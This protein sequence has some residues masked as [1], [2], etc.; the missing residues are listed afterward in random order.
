MTKSFDS[1]IPGIE[2]REAGWMRIRERFARARQAP[3]HPSVTISRQ[4]GCEGYS[5]AQRLQALLEEASGQPWTLFDKALVDQVASDEKLSRQILGHLGDESHAQDVLRTHF[6][7]L[8]HDD[9]YAKV[10][11]HLVHIA[12]AGGAIIVGRGG[13]VACQDLKNCFHFRLEASFEFRTATIARRLEL[14]LPEAEKLVRTQS[15]LREKFISEFLHADVTSSRWYD[16]V[17]NNERQSV[18]AIA[19]SCARLVICAWPDRDYFKHDPMRG[20]AASRA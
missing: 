10:V 4:Y 16:A 1:L 19:Q 6:G 3:P 12:M 2:Q 11:K 9:A 5:L 13:A 17:F 8:T 15:K 20:T 7:H 14:P 18:E